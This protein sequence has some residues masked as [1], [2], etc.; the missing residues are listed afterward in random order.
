MNN[1][2]LF[3]STFSKFFIF[4]FIILNS[5][6]LSAQPVTASKKAVKYFKQSV[7]AQ[8]NRDFQLAINCLEKAIKID[9]KFIKAYIRL[10][11]NLYFS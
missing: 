4:T 3:F 10:S 11:Q 8:Q 9:E 2:N 5:V 1:W 6:L 7:K